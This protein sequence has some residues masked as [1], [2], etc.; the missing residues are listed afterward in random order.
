VH[1]FVLKLDRIPEQ[2]YTG[3]ARAI[4]QERRAFMRVFFDQLDAELLGA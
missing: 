1:E 2:L 3:T 4:A